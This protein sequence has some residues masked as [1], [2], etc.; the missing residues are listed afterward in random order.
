M[1]LRIN[2]TTANRDDTMCFTTNL[3][4]N[5]EHSYLSVYESYILIRTTVLVQV[6][7]NYCYCSEHK[8]FILKQ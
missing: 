4:K 6:H 7:F 3:K 5:I 2:I 8:T 1:Y